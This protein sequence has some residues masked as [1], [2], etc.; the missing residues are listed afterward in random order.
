MVRLL[1]FVFRDL[2]HGGRA[3][4]IVAQLR[5]AAADGPSSSSAVNATT[6]MPLS[7]GRFGFSAGKKK[8]RGS[9]ISLCL[10]QM[11]TFCGC[12]WRRSEH[13][14]RIY[15]LPCVFETDVRYTSRRRTF[16]L[17]PPRGNDVCLGSGG[18]TTRDNDAQENC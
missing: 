10:A 9:R 6:V 12:P 16:E 13:N 2:E 15:I 4:I 1:S 17:H 7:Q 18:F 11:F 14:C 8:E 5:G 3:V